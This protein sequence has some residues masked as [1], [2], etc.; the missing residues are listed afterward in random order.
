MLAEAELKTIVELRF[1][2]NNSQ[3]LLG[4]GTAGRMRD[5]N[6]GFIELATALGPTSTLERAVV[7]RRF[8]HILKSFGGRPHLGKECSMHESEMA[9]IYGADWDEFQSLREQWDPTSRFLPPHNIFLHQVF[10]PDAAAATAAAATS[11]GDG[12]AASA[13]DV[14]SVDP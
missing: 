5:I 1:A 3:A 7:Y 12:A 4:A 11:T 2:P 13:S 14:V 6:V 9:A 10:V 8:D